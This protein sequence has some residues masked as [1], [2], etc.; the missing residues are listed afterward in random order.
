MIVPS[1][2]NVCVPVDARDEHFALFNLLA[3]SID[4][5]DRPVRDALLSLQPPNPDSALLQI[6]GLR[7]TKAP[8]PEPIDPLAKFPGDV[9]DYLDRRGFLFE[10]W[11]QERVQSRML[12]TEL[13]DMHRKITRQPIIVIPTYKCDLKC[14]YCWQRLYHM[15]SPVMTEE[16]MERMFES[17]PYVLE[18]EPE[19]GVDFV[20]FGGEPLQEIPELRERVS[21]IIDGAHEL[22]YEPRIISNG[23]GLASAVPMLAGRVALVQVTI[24][25]P[26]SLHRQRR[27]LPGGDSFAPMVEGGTRALE[28]GIRINIRVNTDPKN[29][30]TLP[31]LSDF[32]REQGW[33]DSKLIH[34]H[35]APVKNHN[36]RKAIDPESELLKEVLDLARRDRRMSIYELDGFAGL[37]YFDS[38]KASG[39]FPLH[40]F[41][42]CEAQIN[43]FAFDL[44]GD[45]YSCW[46]AAGIKEMAVGQFHP[47]LQMYPEKLALWRHRNAMDIPGCTDCVAQPTCGGGCQFLAMEHEGTFQASNCDSL[48]EGWVQSIQ[49]N[50]EWLLEHA[51]VGDHAVGLVT[52]GGVLNE[53]RGEFG[54]LDA[55]NAQD[56]LMNAC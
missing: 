1:K 19:N 14:G 51:R 39:L 3:G 37:K 42:N 30:P 20:I 43:F 50:A 21:A 47:K 9:L 8:A 27:P 28:A 35:I 34:F 29:L 18:R 23:V 12:Y 15:D 4:I 17:I 25:G 16:V 52:A 2:Y 40:R 32:V 44:H 11:E 26:P 53:V 6:Q 7:S 49:A 33:L 36:P 38:F 48:L 10:S 5:I 45:V 56:L 46:D 41:F 13:L 55:G 31:D 22:G 54:I 24:D